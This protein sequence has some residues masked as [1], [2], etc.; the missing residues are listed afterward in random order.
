MNRD[1]H[2]KKTFTV[3][4]SI[5]GSRI[6]GCFLDQVTVFMAFVMPVMMDLN[7]TFIGSFGSND[8]E[9][10]LLGDVEYQVKA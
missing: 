5:F 3:L 6:F 9:I 1:S 10:L 4:K 8:H 2:I 7:A